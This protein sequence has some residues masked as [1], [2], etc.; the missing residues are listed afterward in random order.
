MLKF[1]Y[2]LESFYNKKIL[3]FLCKASKMFIVS[4]NLDE[5]FFLEK[6]ILLFEITNKSFIFLKI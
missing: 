4:L 6:K 2:I 5:I 1:S 3:N